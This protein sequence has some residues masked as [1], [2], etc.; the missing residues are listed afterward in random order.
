MRITHLCILAIATTAGM[1]IPQPAALAQQHQK[2]LEEE[3][4]PRGKAHRHGHRHHH[5]HKHDHGHR[6][7]HDHKRAKPSEK[8]AAKKKQSHDH[9]HEPTRRAAHLHDDAHPHSHAHPHVET[10]HMFGFTVGSDVGEVGHKEVFVDST[11]RFGKRDGSYTAGTQ[12]LEVGVTPFANFH[13]AVGLST[14]YHHISGVS[15]LDDRNQFLFDGVSLEF[16]YR[17]L[18]R[19]TAP[20]GLTFIFEP[21]SARAEEV[22]G[23]R[24]SKRALEFKLA[25]DAEL[26]PERV[27][28]AL[29]LLYEPE[30]VRVHATDELE[31]ESTLGVSGAIAGQIVQDVYLGGEV[32]YLRKYEGLTLDTHVGHAWFV[33][34]TLFAKLSETWWL[35]AAWSVQ[36]A[37]RA[38]DEPDLR[39]DLQNFTRHEAKLKVGAHF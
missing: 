36:V 1:A 39:L 16:K 10:E 2:S 8:K 5:G 30:R 38:V 9:T 13:F 14:A 33:G 15:G 18:D 17:L 22:S 31:K 32:R 29:N 37:G 6:H 7:D 19:A 35:A 20:F 28:A 27:Y 24:V 25:A 21:H 4:D 11:W 12:K 3:F 23:E 26:V 34:P